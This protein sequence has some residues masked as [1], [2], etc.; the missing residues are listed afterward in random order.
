MGLVL[1]AALA[2]IACLA[3]SLESR[4]ELLDARRELLDT[5]RKLLTLTEANDF[6]K[7][8]LGEMTVAL[9]ANP[10]RPSH[11]IDVRNNC[12]PSRGLNAFLSPG[13]KT[14]IDCPKRFEFVAPIS[15]IAA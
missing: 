1:L 3:V 5:R 7:K 15:S 10:R 12:A 8:T 9:A 14:A 2:L 13:R 11:S 4:R 6:L